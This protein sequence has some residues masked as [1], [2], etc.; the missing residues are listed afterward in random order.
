MSEV[1]IF[2]AWMP[3]HVKLMHLVAAKWVAQ[4]LYELARLGV[5][6]LLEDGPRSVEDLA[7]A[8]GVRE[9]P[10][11]RCLRA[12]ASVGVF[13]EQPDGTFAL[14]SMA[15]FLRSGV[16]L[17]LRDLTL[18]L[19][20]PPMQHS[21]AELG[22]VLDSGE[23]GFALANGTPFFEHLERDPALGATYQRAWAP[24]TKGVAAETARRLDLRDVKRVADLGGGNGTFLLELREQHPHLTCVLMDRPAVLAQ[25]T[26]PRL[27]LVPGV[28]PGQIPADVDAYFIKNTLHCFDDELVRDTL[29]AVRRAI[30]DRTDV[31]LHLIESV[32]LPG[33]TYDWGKLLDV[34]LMVNNGGRVHSVEEWEQLLGSCGFALE[35]ASDLVPPQWLL[36]CAPS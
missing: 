19:N 4:P 35:D 11:R 2:A 31:R 13:A 18:L 23:P 24:L 7:A 36:T 33:N 6:D 9:D 32:G 14:T 8:C 29:H 10:L 5:A 30:G 22:S 26:D 28:L 1:D 16:D 17:G 12:A 27:E 21:F 15:D 25:V 20:S 34:E 3:P